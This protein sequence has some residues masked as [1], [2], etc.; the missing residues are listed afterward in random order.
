MMFE[1]LLQL[2]NISHS[3]HYNSFITFQANKCTQL[4]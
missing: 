3:M 1:Q 4:Y 2:F